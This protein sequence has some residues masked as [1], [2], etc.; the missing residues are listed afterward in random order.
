MFL[1]TLA[2]VLLSTSTPVLVVGKVLVPVPQT[3][4]APMASDVR[5]LVDRM[6]AFYEKTEDFQS[7]FVQDYTYKAS[8]RKQTSSGKVTFKKPG[9]MRWDYEKPAPKTFVLAGEKIYAYDP[10]AMTLSVAKVDTSQLSASVT[11]LFGKGR[12]ADEFTIQKAECKTCKGTLL[13]LNPLKKDPRF[14][15]LKLE[16]DPGSAQV[17][18]STVIDPDGSEN[19]IAFTDLKANVKVGPDHFKINPPDGTRIDDYTKAAK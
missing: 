4:P 12:L 5:T 7:N 15:Q 10:A 17:L 13:V 16:V 18:K 2:A 8:R 11:F 1:H 3:A 6:Q 19:T 9:L 14:K